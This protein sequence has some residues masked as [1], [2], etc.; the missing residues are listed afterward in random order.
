MAE[1]PIELRSSFLPWEETEQTDEMRQFRVRL[2]GPLG[3]KTPEDYG[4]VKLHVHESLSGAVEG[5]IPGWDHATWNSLNGALATVHP[6]ALSREWTEL[7]ALAQ[8]AL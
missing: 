3:V 1:L 5:D 6:L 7:W 8:E 4:W 2:P